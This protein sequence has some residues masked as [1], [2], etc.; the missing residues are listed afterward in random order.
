[1]KASGRE[2]GPMVKNLKKLEFL[3]N[4]KWSMT[5]A[6]KVTLPIAFFSPLSEVFT[7]HTLVSGATIF[8]AY[9]CY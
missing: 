9:L 2:I 7:F 5:D 8:I 3:Q 1:M 4:G 6:L